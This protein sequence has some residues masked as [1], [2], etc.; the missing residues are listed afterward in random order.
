[1]SRKSD[2]E[3]SSKALKDVPAGDVR[4]KPMDRQRR[5]ASEVEETLRAFERDAAPVPRADFYA[6]VQARLRRSD[7]TSRARGPL[8]FLRKALLPAALGLMIALNI[9]TAV[10]VS[11][12]SA[13][14]SPGRQQAMLALAQEYDLG[15]GAESGY[16]K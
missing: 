3:T 8:P 2:T 12:R 7:A 1:M 14:G 16:W 6:K 4:E 15:S 11:R 5:I 13:S 9:L 10:A